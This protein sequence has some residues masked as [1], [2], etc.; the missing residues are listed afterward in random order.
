[1]LLVP[2]SNCTGRALLSLVDAQCSMLGPDWANT[3]VTCK[4]WLENRSL[5]NKCDWQCS[6][7]DSITL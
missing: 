1:M 7:H 6:G 3:L 4:G 2:R 5:L